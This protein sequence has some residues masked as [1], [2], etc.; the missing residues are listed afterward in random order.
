[1]FELIGFMILMTLFC[2]FVGTLGYIFFK[3]IVDWA[4]FM[5]FGKATYNP[6]H[7]MNDL[8]RLQQENQM[9]EQNKWLE[10]FGKDK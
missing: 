4:H 3:S 5:M 10:N 2:I 9:R 1:M 6:N 7:R 8:V